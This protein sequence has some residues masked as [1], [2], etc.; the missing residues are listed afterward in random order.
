[1]NGNL[2][3]GDLFALPYMKNVLNENLLIKIGAKEMLETEIPYELG[4][5]MKKLDIPDPTWA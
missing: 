2:E 1:M 5:V 3:Q 4:F